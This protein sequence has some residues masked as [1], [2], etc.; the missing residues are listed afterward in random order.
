MFLVDLVDNVDPMAMV[1][2]HRPEKLN[3]INVQVFIDLE[4]IVRD[5]E[6]D[7]ETCVVILTG[8][9]RSFSVGVDFATLR[10]PLEQSALEALRSEGNSPR[11][12]CG[13]VA[14]PHTWRKQVAD[15][16]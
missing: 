14:I 16:A 1:Q 9:G 3:P 7:Y 12:S 4:A 15:W 10:E 5:L 13:A 6:E 11:D 8:E 2:W